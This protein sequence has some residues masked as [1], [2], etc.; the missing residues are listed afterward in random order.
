MKESSFWQKKGQT[1]GVEKR[2][3]FIE[4]L[5]ELRH[6]IIKSF[7]FLII[8]A[9][10]VYPKAPSLLTFLTKPAGNLV[11][12][13]PT[14]AFIANIWITIIFGFMFASPFIIYQAWRFISSGLK[15]KERKYAGVFGFFSFILF[16]AGCAFGYFLLFPIG[17][18]FLLGFATEI[19]RPMLTVSKYISFLGTFTLVFGLV[20]QLP[21]IILFLTKIGV[22]NP[23]ML[24]RR[25][26]EVI[27]SLFILAAFLT[28]P[29]VVT[30]ICLALPLFILYEVSILLSRCV[31][32]PMP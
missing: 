28:P 23:Q 1:A 13:Y 30:Q 5:E 26:R 8:T 16:L 27:V 2:F 21:L 10:I 29:D 6:R 32:K 4:H 24:S 18:K 31:Y 15:E 11:F 22:V 14:E 12:I 9:I 7:V 17:L 19:I 20:F 3:T 25:R